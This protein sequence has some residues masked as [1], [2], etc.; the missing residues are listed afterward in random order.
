MEAIVCEFNCFFFNIVFFIELV[1]DISGEFTLDA[2][3]CCLGNGT[4]IMFRSDI[5]KYKVETL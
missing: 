3:H 4:K 5:Y 2:K 1:N